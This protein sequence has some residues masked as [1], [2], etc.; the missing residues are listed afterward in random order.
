VTDLSGRV[1]LVT[2]GSSGIG[3]GIVKAL[4]KAGVQVAF[5]YRRDDHCAQAM[6]FFRSHPGMSVLPVHLEVTERESFARVADEVENVLGPISILCNNA[7]VNFFGTLERSTYDDWDW[8]LGVNLGGVINGLV[9]VL[10]RMISRANGGYIINVGSMASF[11]AGPAA[12]IYT[13]SKFAVRG[14]TE[15]L[16]YSLTKYGIKVLLVCPAGTKTNIHEAVLHRPEAYSRTEFPAEA[17]SVK[18]IAHMLSRAMNPDEVG[19]KVVRALGEDLFFVFT[20]PGYADDFRE[21]FDET[22]HCLPPEA[23]TRE[24]SVANEAFRRARRAALVPIS[25]NRTA[26]DRT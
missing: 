6:S 23:P 22:V 10:P 16:R 7:G 8:V 2:G 17:M 3:L 24:Q 13:V 25:R 4:A 1:A 19:E 14:L 9:T 21:I 20:H 15:C 12:G 18:R 11:F 26:D 5:T